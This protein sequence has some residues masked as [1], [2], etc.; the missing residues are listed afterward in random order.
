MLNASASFLCVLAA[1]LVM[2]VA[3]RRRVVGVPHVGLHRVPVEHSDGVGAERVAQLVEHAPPYPDVLTGRV[4]E[5]EVVVLGEVAA[6]LQPGAV[7]RS[8]SLRIWPVLLGV[9][10]AGGR[11]EPVA[12]LVQPGDHD[13]EA[14]LVAH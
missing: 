14:A 8:A 4:R 7:S 11:V 1:S 5:H 2:Q 3:L 12:H 13:L 6:L 10:V 9:Q